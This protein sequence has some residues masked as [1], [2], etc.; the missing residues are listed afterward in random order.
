MIFLDIASQLAA[1]DEDLLFKTGHNLRQIACHAAQLKEADV[2]GG[3]VPDTSGSCADY[4][5]PGGDCRILRRHR[6]HFNAPWVQRPLLPGNRI[7][8]V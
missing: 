2:A 4:L 1:Y 7:Y 6:R 5:G 3:Y 8:Q